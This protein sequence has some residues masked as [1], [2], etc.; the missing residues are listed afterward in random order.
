YVVVLNS[1][2]AL[3][4]AELL[5]TC[6]A[7]L[8]PVDDGVHA[9]N[10]SDKHRAL[11]LRLSSEKSKMYDCDMLGA[12]S[13]SRSSSTS[14]SVESTITWCEILA[15]KRWTRDRRWRLSSRAKGVSTATGNCPLRSRMRA[16]S[17]AIARS[18]RSPAESLAIGSS[19]P[20]GATMVT[21]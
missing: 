11:V 18:C 12:T 13:A 20:S 8:H 2:T 16:L 7:D 3:E 1:R 14:S 5:L 15:K 9:A 17:T 21:A 19:W 4:C 6:S 10:S